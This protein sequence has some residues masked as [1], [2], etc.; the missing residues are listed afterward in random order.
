MKSV[1]MTKRELSATKSLVCQAPGIGN[2]NGKRNET[3]FPGDDSGIISV[4]AQW[5]PTAHL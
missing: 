3:P 2:G 4:A 1:E 5:Q